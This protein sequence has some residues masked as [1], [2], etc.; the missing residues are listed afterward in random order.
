MKNK[1][2]ILMIIGQV[3]LVTGI[4]AQ[5]VGISAAFPFTPDPSAILDISSTTLG[6]LIPRMGTNP[7][8]TAAPANGLLIYNTTMNSLNA[9]I[10]STSAPNW[11]NSWGSSGN[12]LT[13]SGNQFLG[14]TSA[15]DLR[16]RTNNLDRMAIA[17]S[18]LVGIG[19]LAPSST[20]Q[21]NGSFATAVLA[22]STTTP[23]TAWATNSLILVSPG[24]AITLPT[25]A[26]ISGRI[27]TIKSTGAGSITIALYIN[28][29]TVDG[30]TATITLTSTAALLKFITIQT[31]GSVWYII[32]NN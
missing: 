10:G 29:Q 27:Y 4:N 30:G 2:L 5:N 22:A 25:T 32:A 15:F 3:A 11:S 26:S 1:I 14:T 21:V 31:D 8:A 20:L 6:L 24:G 28:T 9:N 13:S 17:S 19:V 16:F 7:P 12:I 18:G 23:G